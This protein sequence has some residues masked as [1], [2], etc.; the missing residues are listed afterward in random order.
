[1][2][3]IADQCVYDLS[4]S[5]RH[6]IMQAEALKEKDRQ[7][8]RLEEELHMLQGRPLRTEHINDESNYTVYG[9][10]AQLHAHDSGAT[11]SLP[12]LQ[13]EPADNIY[14]GSPSLAAVTQEV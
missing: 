9:S 1:M 13:G 12:G 3:Q 14:F 7:I 11:L 8:Q 5:E 4:E 6:P 10:E 2:H